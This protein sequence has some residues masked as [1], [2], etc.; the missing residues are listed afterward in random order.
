[1]VAGIIISRNQVKD[2]TKYNFDEK[3]Q[4]IG[5]FA[6][7]RPISKGETLWNNYKKARNLRN[8][9]S[10]TA[11]WI[12][13][14][15]ARF[16]I[17]TVREWLHF[18][19]SAKYVHKSDRVSDQTMKF[20]S[21]YAIL[22]SRFNLSK[23]SKPIPISIAVRN[24]QKRGCLSAEAAQVMLTAVDYQNKITH[25]QDVPSDQLRTVIRELKELLSRLKGFEIDASPT[26]ENEQD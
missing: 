21:M 16:V 14:T 17:Q 2:K 26:F 10:H 24:A 20:L 4:P 13:E 19:E 11:Q 6:L 7:G 8:K 15:D 18:L 12:G 5:E 25:G 1:M 22:V 23:G 3:L 9:V